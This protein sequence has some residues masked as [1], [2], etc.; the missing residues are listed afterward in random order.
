MRTSAGHYCASFFNT[1][2]KESNDTK[3][4]AIFFVRMSSQKSQKNAKIPNL[5]GKNVRDKFNQDL[6]V[7]RAP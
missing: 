5:P 1:L 4:V 6:A 2:E 3:K 7:K